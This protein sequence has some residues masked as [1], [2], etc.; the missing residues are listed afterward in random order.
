MQE[1]R[2]LDTNPMKKVIE[3]DRYPADVPD[4]LDLADRMGLAINALTNV[5]V[6]EEKWALE[7]DVDMSHRPAVLIL[8]HATDA[9][10]NIPA[11]FLEALVA[12]RAASGSDQHIDRD[13]EV[14]RAQ[15]SLIGED[16][17]TYCPPDTLSKFTE[18]RPFS[19]IW[20]EGRLL[21][22]LSMLA[23]IDDDPRWIEI[24][25]RKVDRLLA[26]SQPKDDYRYFP[27]GRFRPGDMPT[28]GAPEP[29][30]NMTDGSLADQYHDPIFPAVYD[31][32]ALG[33]G[34]GL[35]Y[36][37]SGYEPAL[38][39]A[40]GLAC[41]ALERVFT[42]EDGHWNVF[43]F[44]HSLYSLMA[45][46]EYGV[47]ANDRTML[48]RVDACY[49]WAREMGDPLIGFYAEVMPGSDMYLERRGNTVEICEVSDMVFL[50]LNLTRAGLGDYWDD[51][52]RWVRNMYAEGQMRRT[53]FIDDIPD[54]CFA[55][56]PP[57][58]VYQDTNDVLGRSVGSFW[59]W[60]R[61]NDGL[62][63]DKT[64]EGLKLTNR[65]IMHCCTA[66]GARTLYHVWDSIVTRTDSGQTMVNLLLNRA[67][68]WLDVVSYLPVEGKVVLR[69]K[70][71]PKVSVR[72]PE[73]VSLDKVSVQKDDAPLRFSQAGRSIE[74]DGL[75]PGSTV[76]LTFPVPERTVHRVIGEIPYKLTL[77]GSSVVAI[78]PKG[79]GYPLYDDQPTGKT[80]R[81][82]QF[83]SKKRPLIW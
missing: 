68:T 13:L 40:R 32:G 23:Q 43:H 51:V 19:E 46:C 27:K 20:G 17:L 12:C 29:T 24:G 25:K 7:F 83:V 54:S 64:P 15:L 28:P 75:T 65:A 48:E 74:L 3:G 70:D 69:I 61:A 55:T 41:W 2:M 53:D 37:V 45:V 21:L 78:D 44:H 11:K 81:K 42:H 1:K 4:T 57:E 56:Q 63:V 8:N 22:A 49:R 35:F 82:D 30:G 10:L 62:Q 67:S 80:V 39:L 60:M 71:A 79:I 16:G 66:N 52:D 31:S 18:L 50:A 9:Y 72:M 38:E 14:L 6:P 36:R 77:R 5:W 59:G 33:H 34:A 73:W 47:A 76:Q 26:F 58:Y